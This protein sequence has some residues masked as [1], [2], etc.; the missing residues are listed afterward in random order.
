MA[1]GE[2]Y[3]TVINVCQFVHFQT[4][5]GD[6]HR[7]GD[8]VCLLNTGLTWVQFQSR[9]KIYAQLFFYFIIII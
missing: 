8:M 3:D 9:Y 5:S 2:C 4:W 1:V 7:G 6:F